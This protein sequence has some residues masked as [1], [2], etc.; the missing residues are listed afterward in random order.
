MDKDLNRGARPGT[1]RWNEKRTTYRCADGVT[2]LALDKIFRRSQ[3]EA[4]KVWTQPG[5]AS[6]ISYKVLY[7]KRIISVLVSETQ[8]DRD[9]SR[10]AQGANYVK[11]IIFP[12]TV[13]EATAGAFRMTALLSVVLNE[14]LKTLGENQG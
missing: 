5:Y 12:G 8:F 1:T 3:T 11:T 9:M 6:G 10:I 14:G 2:T 7:D 4:E 13:R